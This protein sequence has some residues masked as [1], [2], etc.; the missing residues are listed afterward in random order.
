MK[1]GPVECAHHARAIGPA[2]IKERSVLRLRNEGGDVL[3]ELAVLLLAFA[4]LLA[5]L[6]LIAARRGEIETDDRL[7]IGLGVVLNDQRLGVVLPIHRQRHS[8]ATGRDDRA[9]TTAPTK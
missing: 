6:V 3:E 5:V 7:R 2:S 4:L 1:A 8:I 9:A